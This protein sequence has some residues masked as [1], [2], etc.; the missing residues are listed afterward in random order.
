[1]PSAF[2]HVHY[3]SNS[4]S[5]SVYKTSSV[6]DSAAN[7]GATLSRDGIDTRLGL[8]GSTTMLL[9]SEEESST[10]ITSGEFPEIISL[11]L[12]AAA[13][14]LL[15]LLLKKEGN[16]RCFLALGFLLADFLVV[17]FFLPLVD[18]FL[19]VEEEARL[20]LAPLDDDDRFRFA[21]ETRPRLLP[22]DAGLLGLA[23]FFGERIYSCALSEIKKFSARG[24][25]TR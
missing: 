8:S 21:V 5:L 15:L 11:L 7:L 2:F 20:F 10:S 9:P 25:Q 4:F 23:V 22:V 19:A 16:V 14:I 13:G 12:D 1:M 6:S 17:F 18:R 3:P 24:V